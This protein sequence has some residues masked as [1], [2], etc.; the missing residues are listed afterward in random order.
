MKNLPK[1]IEQFSIDDN[2][3]TGVFDLK[4]LKE[5]RNVKEISYGNNS[6]ERIIE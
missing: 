5:N 6:F 4:W 2:K 1:S 3:F